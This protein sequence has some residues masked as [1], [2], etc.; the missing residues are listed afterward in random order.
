[1]NKKLVWLV[2][3][4][5]VCS[6]MFST[7][8]VMVA[9]LKES[10][11]PFGQLTVRAAIALVGTSVVMIFGEQKKNKKF[12]FRQLSKY[13]KKLAIPVFL[14]RAAFN[15]CF[16]MAISAAN[17]TIALMVLLFVKMLTNVIIDSVKEKKIPGVEDIFAYLLVLAGIVTYGW[18]AKGLL[19]VVLIW[20][21]ASGVLEAVRLEFIGRL[22]IEKQDKS[23]FAV[24]EFLGMLLV[25]GGFLLFS[26]T[27]FLIPNVTTIATASYIG[28]LLAILAVAINAIDYQLSNSEELP[29]GAY[30]AILATEVGFAGVLNFLLLGSLFGIQQQIGIVISLLAIVAI[31][32]SAAK[33]DTK[34]KKEEKEALEAEKKKSKKEIVLEG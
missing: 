2:F 9:W 5:V 31:G 21:V 30:S 23:K 28:M 10:F 3:L 14:F 11:T 12:D 26:G 6:I 13:D 16:I 15:F 7:S 17:A 19:D 22:K 8:T 1:M 34:K 20:A 33:R 24:L 18:G 29:K 25:V 4:A 32:M 27:G